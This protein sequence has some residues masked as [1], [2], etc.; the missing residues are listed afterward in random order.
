MPNTPMKVSAA[1]TPRISSHTGLVNLSAA[2][3]AS[4]RCI[5]PCTNAYTVVTRT[6][7]CRIDITLNTRFTHQ[8][9]AGTGQNVD[10]EPPEGRLGVERPAITEFNSVAD[11][12]WVTF[13]AEPFLAGAFLATG[14][15]LAA[16]FLA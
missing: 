14:A 2:V 16:D 7:I 12:F 8:A 11:Y 4:D 10:S 9:Y 3:Y 1:A 13:L 6:A 5:A 15:F